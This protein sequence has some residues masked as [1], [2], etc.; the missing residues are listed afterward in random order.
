MFKVWWTPFFLLQVLFAVPSQSIPPE[1]VSQFTLN[2]QIGVTSYYFD[3]S[4]PPERPLVYDVAAVESYKIK[5]QMRGESYYGPTDRFLY[6]ALDQFSSVIKGKK[7]GIVGSTI[8]WYEAIV[9]IYGGKPIA[10]DY[11]KIVSEHPDIRTITVDEYKK[12]PEIFD[13]LIS[14]SSIEHDGLG[15]YGDPIDPQGDLKA[16]KQMKSMLKPEGL[17]F[18]AIPVGIDH[19]YWNAHRVYGSKRLP[20]LLDGWKVLNTCGYEHKQLSQF[21]N[22]WHQPV[23]VLRAE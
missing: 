11:N 17:L 1:L 7:V 10:I 16:M 23:F 6:E 12:C 3:N 5:A 8:P 14:I 9:L 21:S 19:I 20:L 13:A 18:L 2:G 15:R 22:G 4:Y